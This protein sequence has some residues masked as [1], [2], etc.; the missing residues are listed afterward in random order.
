MKLLK[1]I[2]YYT[3]GVF[4]ITLISVLPGVIQTKGIYNIF[5]YLK[6]FIVFLAEFIN[7]DNWVYM[8]KEQPYPILEFLREPFI[9]SAQIFMGAMAIGFFAA[10]ILTVLTQF[11]PKS[12]TTGIK[13]LLSILETVPDLMFAFMLQLFV[14]Y[15]FKKSGVELFKFTALGEEKIYFAPI[16]TLS[17]LPMISLYR[18]F[19]LLVEEEFLKDYAEFALSKGFGRL[20]ILIVHIFRNIF[21]SIYFHSKIIIWGGLSSLFIVETLFNMQGITAYITGDF[22]PIVI[23]VSL[24]LIFTPFFILYQGAQFFIKQDSS[25]EWELIKKD[26][27]GIKKWKLWLRLQWAG[28]ILLSHLKNP[29]FFIGFTFITGLLL[30]SVLYCLLAE[31]PIKN[32]TFLKDAQGKII[33][34]PPHPPSSQMLFG[35]DRYGNSI[36]D[37]I[38]VG[39]RYT[40]FFG[41]LIAVLRVAGGFLFAVRYAFKLKDHTR[42]LIEKIVDSIHFLPLSLIAYLLL[43][44]ILWGQ[45]VGIWAYSF[46][47][48]INLEVLI[49][50]ILVL[51]LTTVLIGNEI[52]QISKETFVLSARTLGGDQKHILWTH[53]FPHLAP[54]LFILFGQQFIQVM[55]IFVHLGLF[56]LFLGGTII[57]DSILPDPPSSSTYEWS[58]MIGSTREAFLSGKYWIIIPVLGAFMIS[59]FAMQLMIQGIKEVQQRKVGVLIPKLFKKKEQADLTGKAP[60]IEEGSFSLVDSGEQKIGNAG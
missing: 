8:Y 34:A 38:I 21:T 39:A 29:K 60:K 4:G 57:S 42:L 12:I 20:R 25:I 30:Y 24:L 14:V 3:M 15:A 52:R 19:L 45:G 7:I 17:I 13:R 40:L 48:R 43:R 55:L 16:L 49:L 2:L 11:L 28:S 53:I 26:I 10:L 31:A 50:T 37:L 9:Y 27:A 1:I 5:A 41:L 22:R 54:R 56:Q 58:G 23:A 51:P 47:E 36:L 32:L 33:S 46:T 35:S 6:A 18:L 59:I 44:P